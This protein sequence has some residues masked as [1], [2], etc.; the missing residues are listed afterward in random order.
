ERACGNR[1]GAASNGLRE[2]AESR[3]GVLLLSDPTPV[4]T[5]RGADPTEIEPQ[6]GEADRRAHLLDAHHDRVF[7]VAAV[8]RVRMADHDAAG[9]GGGHGHQSLEAH[10]GPHRHAEGLVVYHVAPGEG[11]WGPRSSNDRVDPPPGPPPY[12]RLSRRGSGKWSRL[13]DRQTPEQVR[14]LSR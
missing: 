9:R 11:G 2:R 7:H 13:V 4:N 3:R 10:L 5:T 6:G 8:Q 14:H 1:E 12:R